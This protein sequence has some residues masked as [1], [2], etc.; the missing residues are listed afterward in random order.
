MLMS[1]KTN[2]EM[3]VETSSSPAVKRDG[4]AAVDGRH[5]LRRLLP[6]LDLLEREGAHPT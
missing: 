3:S 2:L 4:A 5:A 1:L 6:C